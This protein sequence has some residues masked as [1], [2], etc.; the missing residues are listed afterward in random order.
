[1]A[2]DVTVFMVVMPKK[3]LKEDSA[4]RVYAQRPDSAILGDGPIY[5]LVE[6]GL[7]AVN[8]Q[9]LRSVLRWPCATVR[10]RRT[11]VSKVRVWDLPTRLFHWSLAFGLVGLVV[12]GQMGDSAM[13]WHFRLGYGV[14][15]LLL[16]RLVWGFVGGHWSR[17]GSFVVGPVQIGRYLQGRG[18]PL[19]SVGHNPLGALSVLAL[20]VFSLLQVFTGLFSDDDIATTG[21]LAKMAPSLWVGRATYYHTEI[22]KYVLIALVLLH[23][24][25]LLFYRLRYKNNLTTAMIL[26][27]KELPVAFE[28]ARDDAHSRLLAGVVFAACAGLVTGMVQWA[29]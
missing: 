26:G 25:A 6:N 14:L 22:G 18:T 2:K 1:M 15:S 24:S 11:V 13:V 5:P 23:V 21:P 7:F 16:F 10:T 17:F 27:D 4:A 12:S 19:Q 20:L 3:R 9:F 8:W 29:G 28:S